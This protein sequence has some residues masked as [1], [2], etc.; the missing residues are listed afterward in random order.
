VTRWGRLATAG[1]PMPS[2]GRPAVGSMIRRVT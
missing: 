1:S 2:G